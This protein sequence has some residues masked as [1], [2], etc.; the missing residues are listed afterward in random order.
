MRPHARPTKTLHLEGV[1][2]LKLTT[3]TR[4]SH[5]FFQMSMAPQINRKCKRK[6]SLRAHKSTKKQNEQQR[7]NKAANARE[8]QKNYQNP[9]NPRKPL[10][11]AKGKPEH[12]KPKV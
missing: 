5:L 2:H 8:I 7:N 10:K 3:I 9:E 6:Y 4:L 1:K 12:Q 11:L